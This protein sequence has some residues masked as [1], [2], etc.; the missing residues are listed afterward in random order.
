MSLRLKYYWVTSKAQRDA[1][2][3]D[4]E[5]A[6]AELKGCVA[7]WQKMREIITLNVDDGNLSCV[8]RH[9][10]GYEEKCEFFSPNTGC[11]RVVECNRLVFNKQYIKAKKAYFAQ[12]ELV[13]KFW[14]ERRRERVN[15]VK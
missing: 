2:N 6:C 11:T 5:D 14:E 9:A 15:A 4:Y 10:G 13:D 12:K 7:D 1:D 8:M 3:K